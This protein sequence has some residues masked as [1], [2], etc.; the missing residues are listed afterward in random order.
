MRPRGILI[1]TLAPLLASLWLVQATAG[2]TPPGSLTTM[3]PEAIGGLRRVEL[4]EGTTAIENI[5][6]LHGKA[7]PLED[8]AIATYAGGPGK[9]DMVW[10]S[11]ASSEQE[12]QRQMRDM[13]EKMLATEGSPFRDYTSRET[14]CCVVH[15]FTGM[16]QVHYTFAHNDLSWWISAHPM[17][18]EILLKRF[19]P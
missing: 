19:L 9:P 18:G 6:E 15:E 2:E 8:A 7:I 4:L 10:I 17:Y 1:A 12:N 14:P 11:R 13:V 5:G 3:F 16:G